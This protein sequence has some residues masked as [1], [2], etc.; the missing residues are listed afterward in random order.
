MQMLS[1]VPWAWGEP[2][3]P[4][5]EQLITTA[6][7]ASLTLEIRNLGKR[8]PYLREKNVLIPDMNLN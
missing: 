5:T 8:I 6:I 7:E 1:S 2:L 3:H 4:V